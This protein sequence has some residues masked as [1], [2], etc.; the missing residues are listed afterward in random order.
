MKNRIKELIIQQKITSA[1][2]ASEIG[3]AAS[4]LHHIVSGRNN[5]SLEVLQKIMARFPQ[6]NAEW[7]ING[8]G[9][10]FKEV[11]QGELFEVVPDDK[12]LNIEESTAKQKLVIE[13][14]SKIEES[15][16]KSIS[17]NKTIEKL[18]VLYSDKSFDIY[19]S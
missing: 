4:S 14:G 6:I 3:I 12:V 5:P 10:Q 7:L 16:I 9:K 11:V 1:Q 18:I 19:N 17:T 13:N 2:F 15:I 8:K